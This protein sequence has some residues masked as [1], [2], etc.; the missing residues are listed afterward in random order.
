VARRPPKPRRDRF[1]RF[2]KRGRR[3]SGPPPRRDKLG[4]FLPPRGRRKVAAKAPRRDKRGRYLPAARPRK[5]PPRKTFATP[6]RKFLVT[7]EEHPWRGR[8]RVYAIVEY[9][10]TLDESP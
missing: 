6:F 2:A 3:P 9:E 4:R 1:G 8:Q 7:I 10:S 5:L